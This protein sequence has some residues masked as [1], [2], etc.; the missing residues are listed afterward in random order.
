MSQQSKKE[1]AAKIISKHAHFFRCP[2]CSNQ[3]S[4]DNDHTLICI[5]GHSYDLAK[6]GYIHMLAQSI[7]TK[8]D[9]ALFH[10]RQKIAESGFFH[11]LVETI[12]KL[13]EKEIGQ[14]HGTAILDAGC[15][16]GS[17]LAQIQDY[18]ASD[19]IGFGADISKEGVQL[20]ASKSTKTIWLVAD[21]ANCPLASDKFP[22][23]LNI[24]SPSNY[25]EF[26]RL[27]TDDGFLIKV[28]PNQDYLKELR[29]VFY[30]EREAFDNEK[31]L[32]RFEEKFDLVNSQSVRYSTHLEQP[33][34]NELVKMTPLS[35]SA[36]E[37]KLRRMSEM[38]SMDITVD[39]NILVGKK[40]SE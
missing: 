20:A 10:S 17:H 38:L 4:M 35:W 14:N 23:I 32:A 19:T 18:V 25:A 26:D 3:M 30:E 36:N 33:L 7:N 6:K 28:I 1:I 5:K 22:F 8:Y 11:P 2:I 15:G 12:G 27:L 21:L 31:T 37:K 29:E 16:E 40:K 34:L 13:I 39:L 24:L 9:K